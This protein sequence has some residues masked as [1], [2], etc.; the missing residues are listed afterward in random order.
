[1]ID[2]NS[3]IFAKVKIKKKIYFNLWSEKFCEEKWFFNEYFTIVQLQ[4]KKQK[5]K[6]EE[7]KS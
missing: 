3:I 2:E 5:K 1:M 4:I 7:Y 6:K